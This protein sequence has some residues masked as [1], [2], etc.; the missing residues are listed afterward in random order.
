MS[1]DKRK[2]IRI[3]LLYQKV[4][5]NIAG[6]WALGDLK[7][8]T[9]DGAF[10]KTD[11]QVKPNTQVSLRFELPGDLGDHY[12]SGKVVRVNWCVN[13]KKN[14]DDLG[15]GIEFDNLNESQKRILDAYV[16]YLRN[17]QIISVSKRI[18]EEFYGP[19]GPSKW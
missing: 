19:K 2:S 4:E 9:T 12:V 5:F 6:L 11:A 14:I 1:K 10:I 16:V 18:I 8:I 15:I 17:K 13:K 7:D 3:P